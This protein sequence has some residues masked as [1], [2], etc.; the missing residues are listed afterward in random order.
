M[1]TYIHTYE[2][3]EQNV[4]E[5]VLP[6]WYYRFSSTQ[7]GTPEGDPDGPYATEDAARA[8]GNEE[9]KRL[10]LQDLQSEDPAPGIGLPCCEE[11]LLVF[12]EDLD[13]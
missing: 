4:Y 2:V 13:D 5:D 7:D 11:E 8:A 12:G 1:K 10:I 9:L 3:S 6:G